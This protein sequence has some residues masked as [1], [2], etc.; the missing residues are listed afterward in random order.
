MS[1][2]AGGDWCQWLQ[3]PVELLV[4]IYSPSPQVTK[5]QQVLLIKLHQAPKYPFRG[6]VAQ[7]RKRKCGLEGN[8]TSKARRKRNKEASHKKCALLLFHFQK[9]NAAF[10]PEKKATDNQP[11]GCNATSL[12][13]DRILALGFVCYT[14]TTSTK[15]KRTRLREGGKKPTLNTTI[16]GQVPSSS[17]HKSDNFRTKLPQPRLAQRSSRLVLCSCTWSVCQQCVLAHPISVTPSSSK[18]DSALPNT[19]GA[20][21]MSSSVFVFC[22]C[23][24]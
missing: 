20:L 17:M 1:A 3:P 23:F 21:Q 11:Q 16:N 10:I 12:N 22:F 13:P 19:Y 18:A 5:R 14:E 8:P 2:A 7:E 4:L 9:S 15:I 24:F 6:L